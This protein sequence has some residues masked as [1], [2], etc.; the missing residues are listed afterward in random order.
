MDVSSSCAN[1]GQICR[2][3]LSRRLRRIL[4]PACLPLVIAL[5]TPLAQADVESTLPLLNDP[6]SAVISL[7]QEHRLGRNWARM[8]RAQAPLLED[9]ILKE[10]LTDLVW[11]LVPS[12]QLRDRRLEIVVLD[13]PEF[14]AFAAPGGIVGINAGLMTSA[15]REDD[16]ASVLAHELGHLSQR[17]YAQQLQKQ[18]EDRPLMLAGLLASLLLATTSSGDAAGAAMTGTMGASISS[19]LAFSRRNEQEA[20]RVGMETL[21]KSGYD[22][23]AMPEMFSQLQQRYRFQSKIPEFLQTHPV[24]ESRIADALNRASHM[25]RPAMH[26]PRVNFLIAKERMRAYY[27]SDRKTFAARELDHA[28]KNS[29]ARYQHL[30]AAMAAYALRGDIEQAEKLFNQLPKSWQ[31]DV[32]VQLTRAEAQL[33]GHQPK[34]ALKLIK[35]LYDLYPDSQPVLD[36]YARASRATGDLPATVATLQDLTRRFPTDISY[37]S[38]LGD[39][40]GLSGHPLAVHEARIQYFILTGQF[41]LAHQQVVFALRNKNLNNIER[42][43]LKRT[44]KEISRLRKEMKED[45]S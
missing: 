42:A 43:R 3:S 41:D 31:R 39:A 32:Y 27:D 40:E 22:P 28:E 26:P 37:W 16:V 45:L 5:S 12:S 30:Y 35:P 6:T 17:H 24:T 23:Y 1:K 33:N 19:Q 25:P 7:D 38:R 11:K 9:P 36:F 8:L 14:N 15:V 18:R 4:A 34:Q 13:T 29:D 21:E 44:D 20:D 10:Y 2:R